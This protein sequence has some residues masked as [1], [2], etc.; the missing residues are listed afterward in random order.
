MNE[1]ERTKRAQVIERELRAV[2]NEIRSVGINFRSVPDQKI[3]ESPLYGVAVQIILRHL[4]ND[5][6]DRTKACLAS[7]LTGKAP[8]LQAAWPEIAELYKRAPLGDGPPVKGDSQI[9]PL[10]EKNTLANSLIAAFSMKYFDDLAELLKDKSLGKSR[11][12]LLQ[13]IRRKRRNPKIA[14]LLNE[15][16][17]DDQ[18]VFEIRSWK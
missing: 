3:L 8:E 17:E 4:R 2:E 10:E 15:L 1:S 11:A 6:S 14:E 9:L 16:A 13:A 18:L 5:Y 12:I 7:M